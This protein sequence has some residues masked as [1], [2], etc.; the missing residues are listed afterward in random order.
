MLKKEEQRMTKESWAMNETKYMTLKDKRR[1]ERVKMLLE[2]MIDNPASSIPQA[3]HGE[4][5]STKGAY[6]L[7]GTTEIDEQDILEGHYQ[8]TIQ[9]ACEY[10]GRVVIVSDGMDISFTSLKK[11][12]GLGTLANSEKSLGIKTQNT[13]I[14][15]E[16]LIPLGLIN[17]KYWV[18]NK[19]DYGKKKERI[20]LNIKDKES[21]SWI[22]SL[23]HIE[24][25]LPL[26]KGYVFLGDGAA[27]IY[28]LF[29]TKRRENSDLLIHLVQD[30]NIKNDNVRL[31]KSLANEPTLGIITQ[32]LER[33]KTH[34]ERTVKLEIKVKEVEILP[35]SHRKNEKLSPIK[36]TAIY[37]QEI[38]SDKVVNDPITWRLITTIIVDSLNNAEKLI[39]LYSKRW[40]IERYHYILKEGFRIEKLQM[41]SAGNLK[42]AIALYSIAAGRLLH[43]T[44]FARIQPDAPCSLILSADE[45]NALYCMHNKTLLLPT[46]FVSVREAVRM[47]A[48]LGGFLGRKGDKEPGAKVLWQGLHRLESITQAYVLFKAL[49]V[50]N[51]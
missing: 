18:R 16:N 10:D 50:G 45:A 11:T 7:I 49:N 19:E 31:F 21:Y 2:A 27:D 36:L 8:A 42:R 35:P 41:E 37:A 4:N 30:R 17:Q 22:E 46:D 23:T 32:K 20:R 47:I 14:F 44:Y 51:G 24:K 1:N 33:T 26:E 34:P 25:K 13:Y 6:R 12:T 3:C 48:K 40:L 5:A 38:E 28:D 39:I 15:S 9:K 43:I 29:L